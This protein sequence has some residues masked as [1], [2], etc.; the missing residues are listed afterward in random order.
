MKN[1]EELSLTLQ[2][3]QNLTVPNPNPF[4]NAI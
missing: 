2:T 4:A 3:L 1:Y